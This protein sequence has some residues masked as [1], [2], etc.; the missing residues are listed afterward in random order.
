MR[1]KR[2]AVSERE[3]CRF[4]VHDTREGR[5]M[6]TCRRATDLSWLVSNGYYGTLR[7]PMCEEH[8]DLLNYSLYDQPFWR[9]D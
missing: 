3:R 8:Y 9:G 5:V 2:A 1:L 6:R 7:V 4:R